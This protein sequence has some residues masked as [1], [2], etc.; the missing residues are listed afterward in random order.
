MIAPVGPNCPLVYVNYHGRFKMAGFGKVAF[1]A[2]HFTN[3]IVNVLYY[4]SEDWLP[5]AGNP[6]DEV[7]SF[8]DAIDTKFRTAWL[9]LQTQDTRLLRLEGVGYDNSWNIVTPSPLIKTI[10][11]TGTRNSLATTG[12]F[13]SAN[14]GLRCGQQVQVN[15]IGQSARN[16][17]YLSIGPLAEN[18]CDNYG[19]LESGITTALNNF[20]ALA[21]DHITVL[22]PAVTLIPIRKHEKWQGV[23]GNR[24]LLWRTYSDVLGYTVPRRVA[25]RRSRMGEA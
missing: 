22:S 13:I 1:V 10:D 24:V 15:N 21:D 6:F 7:S 2:E 18:D 4:R 9:A 14:L 12:S 11:A 20:G 19:H 5:L 25:V 17:G 3:T 16:R 8:L 23:F